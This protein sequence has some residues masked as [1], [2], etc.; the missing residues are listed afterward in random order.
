MSQSPDGPNV[1]P[2]DRKSSGAGRKREVGCALVD[3]GQ[4]GGPPEIDLVRAAPQPQVRIIQAR[5]RYYCRRGEW[6]HAR[7]MFHNEVQLVPLDG[8][9]ALC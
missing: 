7:H 2:R 5:D 8:M 9:C 3:A 4:T 6:E 1:S